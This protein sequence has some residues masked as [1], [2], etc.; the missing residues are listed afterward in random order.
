MEHG[1]GDP[2]RL[3]RKKRIDADKKGILE[4]NG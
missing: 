4:L 2:D 3:A 1:S